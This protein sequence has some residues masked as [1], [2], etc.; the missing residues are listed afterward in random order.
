LT[1]WKFQPGQALELTAC[2][3][4][5]DVIRQF[6]SVPNSENCVLCL[7][8][9]KSISRQALLKNKRDQYVIN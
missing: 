9:E 1:H 2:K 8:L 4:L 3:R 7:L 5:A 6:N